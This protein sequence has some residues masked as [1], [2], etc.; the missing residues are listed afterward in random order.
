MSEKS[1]TPAE[2]DDGFVVAIE[3][4]AKAGEEEAV[5]Q[6]L[7]AFDQA[8]N[9]GA[10]RQALPALPFADRSKGVFCIRV[11]PERSWLG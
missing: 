7:R 1:F 11:V 2:L 8:D 5:A 3:I 4:D 10:G 6:A 9:G